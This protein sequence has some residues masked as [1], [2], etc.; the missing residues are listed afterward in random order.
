MAS[1]DSAPRIV[2]LADKI[3]PSVAELQ[4]LLSVQGVLSPSWAEDN[5]E[6]LP[7]DAANLQDAVLDATAELHE[8]LLTLS[9]WFSD[10][11][12]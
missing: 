2:A 5:P 8:L 11:L 4:E 1:P 3:S 9:R 7:A 6:C 10:S 12:R